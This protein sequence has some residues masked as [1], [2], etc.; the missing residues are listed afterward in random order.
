VHRVW[1]TR[2]YAGVLVFNDSEIDNQTTA[3][4]GFDIRRRIGKL[5]LHGS[6][7]WNEFD[8]GTTNT[9]DRRIDVHAVRRF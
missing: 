1:R 7:A 6:L 2:V 4:A 8:R 5:T 9:T 3:R